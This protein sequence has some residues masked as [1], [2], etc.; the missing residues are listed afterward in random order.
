MHLKY[1]ITFY[2]LFNFQFVYLRTIKDRNDT[3][4]CKYIRKIITD[5]IL[6]ECNWGGLKGK[7]SLCEMK[8]FSKL[9]YAVWVQNKSA[10]YNYDAFDC[11]MRK[12]IR[13]AKN[14]INQRTHRARVSAFCKSQK[15]T[16]SNK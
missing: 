6:R 4:L 7:K 5:D 3:T 8:I 9:V 15:S 1:L 13:F 10:D 12:A 16:K 14:R 2:T 11:D